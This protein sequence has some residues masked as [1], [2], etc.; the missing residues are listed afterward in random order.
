MISSVDRRSEYVE[1][2]AGANVRLNNFL[3][4]Y[5]LDDK[6]S[7]LNAPC[8]YSNGV[9]ASLRPSDALGPEL[10]TNGDFATDSDFILS[11]A[12]ISNNQLTVSNGSNFLR[13][14]NVV[15]I[16]KKYRIIVNI[17]SQSTFL[18]LRVRF[19]EGGF[20][21]EFIPTVGENTIIAT[22][23]GTEFRLEADGLQ[24]SG[25]INSVSVKEDTSADF[26]F[27]RGSAATRVTK[28]GLVKNVQILSDELVQ[29]GDFS[30]IGSEEVTNGDFSQ[31]GSELVTNG[32]FA[33]DSDW[34][35]G[36]GWTIEDGVAKATSAPFS[37]SIYQSISTQIN[38]T[39]KVQIEIKNYISGTLRAINRGGY[40][41]LPQSN[42]THT[43]Y[44]QTQSSSDN[45][46]YLESRGNLTASIDNVSVKEVGQDW[47]FGGESELTSEG[48]RVYSSDG[49]FSS[50]TQQSVLTS[51]KQY[52]ITF[53]VVSTNGSNLANPSGT[54]IYDTSTVGSKV[55]Y[56]NANATFFQLKRASGVTDVTITNISV[57]EVGQNWDFVGDTTV[58]NNGVKFDNTSVYSEIRQNNIMTPN[59]KIRLTITVEDY[60][61]GRIAFPQFG[62]ADGNGDPNFNITANGTY[63]FE[64]IFYSTHLTIKRGVNGT[65]LVVSNISVIEITEDTDLPRID[66]TNGTGSLLL[67]PQSTNLIRYSEDFSQPVWRKRTSDSTQVPVITSNYAI[68]PDGTQN[69]T[70]VVITPPSSDSDYAVVDNFTSV[71]KNVGDKFTCSIYVKANGSLQIGKKINL[72]QFENGY[73]TVLTHSLTDNWVRLE[74]TN[75]MGLAT[76]NMETLTIG[77]ARSFV[78][79]SLL[80]DMATD[81]LIAFAQFEKQSYA[82][83]YIPNL[84]G[85][86][87]GVTRNADVCNNAGSSDL[88]NSTE[89]VL[90]AEVKALDDDTNYK[91][92]SV[93]DGSLSNRVQFSLRSNTIAAFVSVGGSSQYSHTET[94]TNILDYHKIALVYKQNDYKLFINGTL[95]DSSA[96][97]NTFPQNTLTE[98]SFTDGV[99]SYFYGNVRSIAVFKEALTDEELAKITSTT[100]QEVF[101]EMRDKMLQID[102]D[103]YEFGDYTTRLKKLF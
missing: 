22:A 10:V 25:V 58:V 80:S 38:K 47:E 56:Y 46:L 8:G 62:V 98:L 78:G 35:K 34:T 28:D 37:A 72:Y 39:Y 45:N 68:S 75:T 4:P 26:S 44:L 83:S 86:V 92:I 30:Q 67:E 63:V 60:V 16:G 15:E 24:Y 65:D 23:D 77:K 103:Y 3:T 64:D 81:F 2:R 52:K 48:V 32:N 19:V 102:A 36:T 55:F 33:T 101:Y 40:V 20:E 91:A 9:Y 76:G 18:R 71:T 50:I 94:V 99:S 6:S 11:N 97:G 53:D 5:T 74:L 95:V 43:I 21:N 13:Q 42:G 69:A 100:Q 31:I 66:Y 12:T 85:E 70:R 59:S 51:G 54:F 57:K 1:N 82:T 29:N 89:G 41:D 88:I 93:S 90:Y 96:V 7:I 73:S 27:T 84:N 79:G 14:N 87:N 61:G 17:A 49:S